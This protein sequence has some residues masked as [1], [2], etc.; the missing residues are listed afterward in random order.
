ML[1]CGLW[2]LSGCAAAPDAVTAEDRVR[3]GAHLIA[4]FPVEN[5]S[6]RPAPLADVRGLL[7][8]RLGAYG[9]RVLDEAALERAVARHR[10]RYTAGVERAFA[11][12][13]EQDAGAEAILFPS[14]DV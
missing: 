14:P 7:T 10:V 1:A 9:L 2:G 6:G 13:L 8:A 5:L 11:R 4:V 3:G 12:A